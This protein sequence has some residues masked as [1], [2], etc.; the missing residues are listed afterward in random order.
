MFLVGPSRCPVG[1][2]VCGRYSFVARMGGE[3]DGGEDDDSSE[4]DDKCIYTG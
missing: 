4:G 3:D 1:D 2:S